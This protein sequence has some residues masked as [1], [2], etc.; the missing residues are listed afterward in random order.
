MI[1]AGADINLPTPEGATALMVALDNSHNDV[2]K[3]LLDKGANPHLW[4]VYGRT[5]LYVAVDKK[6]VAGAGAGGQGG[7]AGRGGPGGGAGAGGRGGGQGGGG[8]RGGAVAAAP[9]ALRS[10]GP[11]VSSLDVINA[12]LAAGVDPNAQLN[13]RRPSNQGGRFSDPLLS[14]GTTPLL[15]AVVNNDAEAIRT[16]LAKGANP[17]II[18]MG[19]SPFLLAAGAN[20]YGGRGGGAAPVNTEI[21]DLMLKSGAD[22]N[23]QVTGVAT[24]SMRIAR[25]PSD[26]EGI[27]AL[28]AA[29]LSARPDLVKFL[30]DHGARAD[31]VDASGRTPLDILSG[32]PGRRANTNADA[33]GL[34]PLNLAI[35]QGVR[36]AVAA[37]ARG[38]PQAVQEIRTLLE[39][40]LKNQ[41]K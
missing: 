2:A 6:P 4:D 38:N 3:L 40:A 21:L 33:S 41:Q 1:A 17:N 22:V 24:Y 12:L 11:P 10:A 31:I 20:P 25:S 19:A 16:V 29:V 34:A 13:M 39:N 30:L 5:A 35:P 27:T 36:G 14:T 37:G 28:H 9:V 26:A 15:R 18:G 7:G 32:A 23:A 8:G